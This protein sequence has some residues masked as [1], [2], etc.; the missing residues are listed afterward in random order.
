MQPISVKNLY[1]LGLGATE[2]ATV[3]MDGGELDFPESVI[4]GNIS[5]K[6]T[7]MRL[8]ESVAVKAELT[9]EVNLICD[10][11]LDNFDTE[12]SFGFDA[13]YL[14]D[15]KAK[16]ED[17]LYADKYLNIDISEPVHDELLLEIP[18][19]NFCS[20]S[21]KGICPGCGNNLNHEECVCKMKP[22]NE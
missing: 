19:Q 12:V 4:V 8:E 7:M 15:R 21:C 9:A 18:T 22:S 13:E 17:G 3:S 11:C 2:N 1:K 20:Q 5:G 6:M 10:R 16:S 14:F